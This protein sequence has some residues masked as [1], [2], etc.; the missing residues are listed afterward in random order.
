MGFIGWNRVREPGRAVMKFGPVTV[1]GLEGAFKLGR[2]LPVFAAFGA[3]ANAVE[4]PRFLV[5]GREQETARLEALFHKHHSPRTNC[6]LWDAWIPMSSVWPAVGEAETAGEM[7]GWIRQS[8]LTR[9]IDDQG[10]VTMNQHRGLAHPGGWPFPTWP[11]AGGV[12]WHFTHRGDAYAEMMKVPL[13][14]LEGFELAGAENARVDDAKGLLL[15][16]AG[17]EGGLTTPPFRVSASVAPF[18]VV[19]WT[20]AQPMADGAPWLEWTTETEGGFSAGRRIRFSSP[21]SGFG[22]QF[23]GGLNFSVIPVHGHPGW[24]GT[25]TRL[26]LGWN[27]PQPTDLRIRAIHTA[28][29]SRHPVTGMLFVQGCADYFEWTRDVDFLRRN[30]GRIRR[31]LAFAIREFEVEKHGCVRVPWVGHDGRAG[32]VLDESGRKRILHGHGVG[33]NYWDLLPF[34]HKDCL[35]T[36]YLFDA[37]RRAARLEQAVARHPEWE[38]AAPECGAAELSELA[39]MLRDR[40]G[41]TFW[42]FETG[43]FVGCIDADGKPHDYGFTFLNNEAIHY[44]FATDGQARSILSWTTGGRRVEGDTSQGEDIYHW[45]FAPRATTRRNIDWYGWYWSGPESIPWGG[46]VQDGG[47][48]LGFSYHDLMAR[49]QVLGPDDAWHRLREILRWFGE[50]EAEGGYRAYYSKPGR[51]TLQGGGTAGGLGL[52]HE[53]MESVLVPQVVLYGFLGLRPDAEGCS[54]HPRRPSDWPGLT[55]TRIH[56]HDHVIDVGVEDHRITVTTRKP[57]REPLRIRVPKGYE[58]HRFEEG[59][60]VR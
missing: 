11:Q 45:R 46:Q 12:G 28:I 6:T 21:R 18:V 31:A 26:R 42:N 32:F 38:I 51:G 52:D 16:T 27:H 40:A 44:G 17:G 24:D 39:A 43:R 4:L 2:L 35:A 41:K 48:V 7:R 53:F 58:L 49:L 3:P 19:E 37:L 14:T 10:Y 34:G 56:L 13:A 50:V 30:I 36:I 1:N 29:D 9:H 23:A 57:G 5:P 22:Q 59:T 8:L 55:I 25:I 20:N 47:A 54:I 15:R 33:N 60:G